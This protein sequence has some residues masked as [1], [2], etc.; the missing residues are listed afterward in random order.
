MSTVFPQFAAATGSPFWTPGR[1]TAAPAVL[2]AFPSDP[3]LDVS[4]RSA[5]AH[6]LSERIAL[7]QGPPGCGK[8]FVGVLITRL[9]LA[10]A[11]LRSPRPI[12]FVCQTNHALDQILEHVYKFDQSIVRLG[13]RSK[14][15]VM[16]SLSLDALRQADR[17][18]PG[19]RGIRMSDD[20]LLAKGVKESSEAALCALLRTGVGSARVAD[21]AFPPDVALARLRV[22]LAAVV[23]DTA[24]AV[25]DA[26]FTA[27]ILADQRRSVWQ[28]A[29]TPAVKRAEQIATPPKPWAASFDQWAALPAQEQAFIIAAFSPVTASPSCE[30]VRTWVDP[31]KARPRKILRR[32]ATEEWQTVPSRDGGV[33][34][35]PASDGAS[36]GVSAAASAA[37][38]RTDVIG[39]PLPPTAVGDILLPADND[40]DADSDSEDRDIAGLDVYDPVPD[41]YIP[42][43][44]SALVL[45]SV[46]QD[47]PEARAVWAGITAP[48]P[49]GTLSTFEAD[50]G[51]RAEEFGVLRLGVDP[52]TMPP[53]TRATLS[54]AWVKLLMADSERAVSRHLREYR[55]AHKAVDDHFAM[56]D[57]ALLAKAHVIGMTTT[58][59]A[60]LGPLLHKLE[61]QVLALV[62]CVEL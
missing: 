39:A 28:A 51:L 15:E 19:S 25:L 48:I 12:V 24:V 35:D 18:T 6:A 31:V 27:T 32:E 10:N 55:Q 60:K 45:P 43:A 33:S 44:T 54:S 17:S 23:G 22:I 2:P 49:D 9:L 13:G 20:V 37:S 62:L 47:D 41:F 56:V 59:A 61:P 8:T 3:P 52:A 5:I 16:Q 53:S 7:I 50:A 21:E 1:S 26:V 58:G 30:L 57:A 34:L 11:R 40:E 29:A 4:Q 38:D 36:A 42:S 46:V 14:S